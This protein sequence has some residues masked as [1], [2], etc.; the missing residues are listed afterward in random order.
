MKWLTLLLLCSA[1]VAQ[2][3]TVNW[4]TV[5]QTMDGFGAASAGDV[6]TLSSAQMDFF[7]TQAGID[8]DYIRLKIYP[9]LT[10]CNTDE[11]TGNCISVSSG[12]TL[13]VWDLAN[14]QAALA[15]GA[16]LWAAEWSPLGYMKTNGSFETGGAMIGNSTNYTDLA[17]IQ[18]G[19]VTLLVGTYGIPVY[20]I[21]PQNEPDQ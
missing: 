21:F 6:P 3:V 19:F 18:A 5:N 2:T 1:C 13:A 7:Y 8:L 20:A 15:R 9:D 4:D 10:D 14:A 16:T 12:P 11:G 17:A